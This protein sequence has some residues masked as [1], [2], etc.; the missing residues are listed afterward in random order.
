[1][2]TQF[3]GIRIPVATRQKLVEMAKHNNITLSKLIIGY[4]DILTET[5]LKQI[6]QL[7]EI[8]ARQAAQLVRWKKAN[9]KARQLVIDELR[10]YESHKTEFIDVKTLSEAK[11]QLRQATAAMS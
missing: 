3:T 2:K 8:E 9:A 4:L 7:V 11:Q 5:K 6:E 10:E 1:M